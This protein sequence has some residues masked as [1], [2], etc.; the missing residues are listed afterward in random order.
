MAPPRTPH[1]RRSPREMRPRREGAFL[2]PLAAGGAGLF[3]LLGLTLQGL[4]LQERAQVSALERLGREEDLLASAAHQLLAALNDRHRCLLALPLARWEAEGG[5]CASP[6]ALVTLRR[7]V[8]WS[9]PV[10]LRAWQPGMDGQSAELELLLEAGEGRAERR[11][12]FGARLAGVPPLAVD[13]HGR[14]LGG[15]QP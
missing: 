9:V 4:A 13:P 3:L 11:A 5:E 6:E 15:P 7:L 12:Q 10:R 8:V 2:M 14:V 1:R